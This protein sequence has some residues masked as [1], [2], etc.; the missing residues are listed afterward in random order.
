MMVWQDFIPRPMSSLLFQSVVLSILLSFSI[1]IALKVIKIR[2]PKFISILYLAPMFVPLVIYA[3]FFPP[4]SIFQPRTLE[5]TLNLIPQI[6]GGIIF[7][8]NFIKVSILR[9]MGIQ[10]LFLT[11]ILCLLGLSFGT[12]LLAFLYVFGSR[13]VC[14]LQGVVELTPQEYPE[15]V[16]M[17]QRLVE[18][19]GVSMPRLGITEDLRPN[20]FTIGWGGKAMIVVTLGI[21]KMLDGDELE[22]VMA[23]EIAHIKNQDFHFMALISSLRAISFF[24]PL[25][26]I[27]S[28]AIRKERELFADNTGTKLL[29]SPEAFG[30]ALTKIWDASKILPRSFLIQWISGLFIVSEIKHARNFLAT[31]PTLENRLSSISESRIRTNVSKLDIMKTILTCGVLISVM[32]CAFGLLVQTFFPVMRMNSVGPERIWY[33]SIDTPADYVTFKL[34]LYPPT[35]INQHG[36]PPTMMLRLSYPWVLNTIYMLL[37]SMILLKIWRPLA[38]FNRHSVG[39]KSVVVRGAI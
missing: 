39:S 5:R 30:L 17:T 13:I 7:G 34:H 32:L 18:R 3:I 21:L 35:V 15:L 10:Y 37:I 6:K 33:R 25:V 26:Y 31:H 9:I 20:A 11:D 22:A 14:K 16:S 1:Y 27:L 4:S 29:E 8:E 12:A 36:F 24:N 19:A 38:N 2:D 23:H 28:P